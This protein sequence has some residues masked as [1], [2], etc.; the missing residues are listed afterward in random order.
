MNKFHGSL[1]NIIL[2]A[3]WY[4][5]ENKLCKNITVNDVYALIKRSD[6]PRAYTTVKTVMDRLVEKQYLVRNK[7]GKRFAYVSLQSRTEL[8]EKA[9][10]KLANTYFNDDL[11][12]LSEA[13]RKI[14]VSS[15][16]HA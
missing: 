16:V 14:C 15:K 11:S 6:S 3:I 12:V 7:I 8:A 9:I 2:N 10:L 5:E 1:E 4:I 13:V